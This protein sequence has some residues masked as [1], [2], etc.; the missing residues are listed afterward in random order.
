MSQRLCFGKHIDLLVDFY[1]DNNEGCVR[2]V[3]YS[4]PED[5]RSATDLAAVMGVPVQREPAAPSQKAS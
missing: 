4:R 5:A 3:I 1:G 2:A